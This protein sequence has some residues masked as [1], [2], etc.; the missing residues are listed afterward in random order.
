MKDFEIYK[1]LE[2]S[3]NDAIKEASRKVS[4]SLYSKLNSIGSSPYYDRTGDLVRA[5]KNPPHVSIGSNGKVNY[6]LLDASLVTP[7]FVGKKGKFNQHMSLN[8][9]TQYKGQSL[10]YL[11]PTWLDEGFKTPNGKPFTGLHYFQNALHAQNADS[12]IIDKFI[13]NAKR[14]LIMY[15]YSITKGG[16]L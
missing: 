16:N 11:I 2:K 13:D 4:D 14:D 15:I 9:S 1:I 8:G 10:A 6:K 3:L 12:F 7:N 5:Y